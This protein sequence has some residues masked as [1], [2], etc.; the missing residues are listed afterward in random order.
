MLVFSSNALNIS[1]L[2]HLLSQVVLFV[3]RHYNYLSQSAQ[4]TYRLQNVKYQQNRTILYQ[5]QYNYKDSEMHQTTYLFNASFSQ[6][7]ACVCMQQN[8]QIHTN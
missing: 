7:H 6:V 3:H 4:Y 5:L 2:Q 1:P 8:L